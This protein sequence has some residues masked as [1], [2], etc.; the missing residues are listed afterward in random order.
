LLDSLTPQQFA[1]R[2]AYYEGLGETDDQLNM[3]T[4][5]AL[6]VNELRHLRYRM[7]LC[8]GNTKAKPDKPIKPRDLLRRWRSDK[9]KRVKV[10]STAEL[11]AMF[12]HYG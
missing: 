8:A 9:P 4:M 12:K 10:K 2:W 3:A 1:E 5:T 7:E 6:I 11:Y